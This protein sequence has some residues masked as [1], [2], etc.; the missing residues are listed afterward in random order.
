MSDNPILFSGRA[1]LF[2]LP[3]FVLFPGVIHPLHIF[4]P[5]YRQLTADALAGDRLIALALLRPGWE[6]E[7]YDRPPIHPVVCLGKIVSEQRLDDGRYNLLLQ[8]LSRARVVEEVGTDRLYRVARVELLASVSA[9]SPSEDR[10]LRRQLAENLSAWFPAHPQLV[11]QFRKLLQSELALGALGDIL[12]FALPLD[13]EVKQQLL[14]EL[15]VGRRIRRLLASLAAEPAPTP[16]GR[17]FPPE[18]SAN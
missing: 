1:R 12:G 4:E 17:K 11:E 3:G 18:F 6:A 14:E 7:Y 9:L 16:S 8:G 10:R 2:P 13:A 5:R 15:D